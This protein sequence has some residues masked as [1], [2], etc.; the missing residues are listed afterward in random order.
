MSSVLLSVVIIFLAVLAIQ[1]RLK[2][3]DAE[4]KDKMKDWQFWSATG[5]ASIAGMIILVKA[6]SAGRRVRRS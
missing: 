1:C 3:L 5:F 4:G 6:L 2:D